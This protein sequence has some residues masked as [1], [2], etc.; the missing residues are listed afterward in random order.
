V[1]EEPKRVVPVTGS[2]TPVDRS[3]DRSGA[4]ATRFAKWDGRRFYFAIAVW[5]DS[6]AHFNTV[7]EVMVRQDIEY[8]LIPMETDAGVPIGR[9]AGP[10]KVQ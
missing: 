2:G 4:V 3:G 6:F 1:V 5:P 7:R 8:Q 9:G 10:G